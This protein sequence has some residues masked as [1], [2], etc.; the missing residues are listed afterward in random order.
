MGAMSDKKHMRNIASHLCR[1]GWMTQIIQAIRLITG[2]E[3]KVSPYLSHISST[4]W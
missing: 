3:T 2:K 4:T 1:K